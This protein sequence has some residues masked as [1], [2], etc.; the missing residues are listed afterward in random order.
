MPVEPERLDFIDGLRGMAI[1]GVMMVH[2]SEIALRPLSGWM[3]KIALEATHGVQL[4]YLASAFTLLFS[5][6]TRKSD[7]CF[8]ISGFYIRRFFRIAPL[9]YLAMIVYL[10]VDGFEPRYYAPN[11]IKWW[12]IL[13]TATFTNGWFPTAITSIITG[14]W[15]VAIEMNFYL[16]LPLCFKYVTTLNRALWFTLIALMFHLLFCK[17]AAPIFLPLF[18]PNHHYLIF[19]F[20]NILSL[21]AQIGVFGLGFIFFHL[22]FSL[23]PPPVKET[24]PAR[25]SKSLIFFMIFFYLIAALLTTEFQ[26]RTYILFPRHFVYGIAFLIFAY[27]LS[28]Y[29]SPIFVNQLTKRIGEISYSMYLIHP[30][31]LKMIK[32]MTGGITIPFHQ[33][34]R[35]LLAFGSLVLL[36]YALSSITHTYIEK[37]GMALGRRIIA[38][39]EKRSTAHHSLFE[40]YR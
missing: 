40:R 26:L 10:L 19:F 22:F 37:P 1:L 31:I 30:L 4:F 6:H 29:P 11:G 32:K 20:L 39:M 27:A 33:D 34:I 24:D 35:F 12:H 13:T 23:Q 25:K 3:L 28:L 14:G 8:R 16:F 2:T 7:H 38:Q 9:F 17:V 36:T 5:Y 21:P 15:S 18:P